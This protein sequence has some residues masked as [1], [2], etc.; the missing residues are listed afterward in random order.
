ARAVNGRNA[1]G[2]ELACQ[3]RDN[4]YDQS[5]AEALIAEYAQ[6]VGPY[7]QHGDQQPYTLAEGLASVAQAY[8]RP[9][10]QP[11]IVAATSGGGPASPPPPSLPPPPSSPPPS[12]S[13]PP[14]NGPRLVAPGRNQPS[15]R[16]RIL[17]RP[18]L[19]PVVEASL[20]AL[21]QYHQHD[22]SI[23]VRG[24]QL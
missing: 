1:A 5:E 9:P 7:D 20:N 16:R 10:R 23:F 18:P 13:P 11:W 22:P 3:A 15:G 2:F 6:D 17:Y 8:S 14:P 19:A 24:N 12:G 4:N 21:F